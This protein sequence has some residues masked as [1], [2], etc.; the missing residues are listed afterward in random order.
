MAG[1]QAKGE[2]LNSNYRPGPRINLGP[3]KAPESQWDAL[4]GLRRPTLGIL[5]ALALLKRTGGN[6][7]RGTVPAHVKARRRARNKVAKRSRK[8]NRP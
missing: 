8:L 1:Q 4:K 2:R 5:P 3:A 6:V 7:Y